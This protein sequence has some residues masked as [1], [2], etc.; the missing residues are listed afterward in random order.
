MLRCAA[1]LDLGRR[2][3]A[4]EILAGLAR[5]G[6]AAMRG[7]LAYRFV[8]DLLSEACLALGDT[9]AAAALHDLLLPHQGRLLGW[10]VT[11]L[12]LARLALARD[13][14]EAAGR[15]L[16]AALALVRRSGAALYE[17]PILA[18]LDRV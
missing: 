17:K 1:L 7:D 4:A 15:R 12:C 13:D 16:R 6:F 8:P 5:D 18:L 14:R 3:E 2:D 11:D 10:S 9:A